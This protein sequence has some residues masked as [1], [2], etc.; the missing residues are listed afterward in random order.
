MATDT[1]DFRA[2]S[3]EQ[4]LQAGLAS[5][6]AFYVTGEDALQLTAL[7][8]ATG[9]RL[10]VSGRFMGL[11]GLPRPFV[12]SLTPT[13]DR[14]ASS[15]VRP[16]GE[17]WILDL[18]VV[19]AAGS[20]SIGQCWARVQVVRGLTSVGIVLGTLVSG[21]VTAVQPIAYPRGK[22]RGTLDGAGLIR[23]ITGTDPAAGDEISET[24]PSGARW[25]LLALQATLVTDATVAN[26]GPR[27]TFDD[28]T[29][30]CYSSDAAEVQAAS[31]TRVF[32]AGQGTQRL[33][34]VGN[35]ASWQWPVGVLL[36]AG[37]RI[38]TST[39]ALQV[40]DNWGAPQLVVEEW[41][42]GA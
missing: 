36:L 6:A 19:A 4:R 14:V 34:V 20:P 15:I 41:L 27:L 42:E 35:R 37:W 2:L 21:Y 26:R 13:T 16:L 7:N 33:A 30:E 22:V 31:V 1:L 5:P 18:T 32:A 12:E 25:K 9:V 40:G 11:D 23:S 39:S 29:T 17:G 24:V 8:S 28:G 3:A 10:T 38:R